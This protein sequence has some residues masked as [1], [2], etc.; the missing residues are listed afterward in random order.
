M[1]FEITNCLRDDIML[2]ASASND[3]GEGSRIYPA[4]Y[5]DVMSIH[6]ANWRGEK[7][8]F[9][10]ERYGQDN[11]STVGECIRPVWDPSNTTESQSCLQYRDETSYATTVAVAIAAFMIAYIRK[12]MPETEE[13]QWGIKP[14]SPEGIVTI[15]RLMA[16]DIDRYDWISPTSF[17]SEKTKSWIQEQLRETLRASSSN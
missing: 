17:T 8:G 16:K 6:S 4:M 13:H 12:T 3:C 7:S 15:F 11:F 14:W 1:G 10:P 5:K 2:F 9:N